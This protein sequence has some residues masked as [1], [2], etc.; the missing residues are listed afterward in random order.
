MAIYLTRKPQTLKYSYGYQ[1][2][3]VIGALASIAIIWGLLIWLLIEAVHRL[4]N[5]VDI[6]GEVMLI[7][8]IFGL[9][10]NI[11]NLVILNCCC[12]DKDRS[13]KRIP[14]MESIASAYKPMHGNSISKATR[15]QKAKSRAGDSFVSKRS[16]LSNFD[17]DAQEPGTPALKGGQTDP[18]SAGLT[19]TQKRLNGTTSS[20]IGL[21]S[22]EKMDSQGLER[23]P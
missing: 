21:L 3:D 4:I 14:L 11:A 9:G 20:D 7:T 13:G 12:N 19:S 18:D 1:R 6:D 10:C 16:Q 8:A 23:S 5:P 2:A 22:T 17:A 15:S